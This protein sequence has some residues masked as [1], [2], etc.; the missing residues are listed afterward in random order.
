M[1]NEP[2]AFEKQI[3]QTYR[4]P[5][6]N[7]VFVD[8]L[9][10]RFKDYQPN[11]EVK[12]Q[13]TFHL[14]RG[15]AFAMSVLFVLATLTL[16]IGPAKVWAQIQ[17][18]LGFVPGVGLVD[19][20]SPF[21]QLAAPV[22]ATKDG[23]T[24][25]IQSA[26][27][28][29]DQTVITYNMSELPAD[30]KR[31]KFTDPEC[32]QSA[33]L[34]LPDGSQIESPISS[35][36]TLPDGSFLRQVQFLSPV[37]V[38]FNQA[39]LVFPC[40]EG[41]A[42]E[43]GLQNWQFLLKF[44]PAPEELISYPVTLVPSLDPSTPATDG[45]ENKPSAGSQASTPT[46]PVGIVDGD[47]QED[48]SLLSVVEK[49]D[50][51]WVTWCFPMK[52]DMNVQ[53]NGQ[54]YE[55]PFN[56]VLYD[57]N[58][59][60]LP[61]PSREAQLEIWKYE[62]GLREQLSSTDRLNCSSNLHTFEI[63]KSGVAFPVYAR[64]NVYERSFPEKQAFAD[65]EFDGSQVLASD[66]PIKVDKAIQIGSVKFKLVSIGKN[67]YGGYTFNFDGQDGQ[68]ITAEIG[69]VG[70]DSNFHGT[71]SFNSNDPYH[72]TLS[73][74]YPQIP[75]GSLT[76]RVS[77]PAVLGDLISFIGSWSPDPE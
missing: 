35:G 54:L 43:K 52:Y 74:M 61:E 17:S 26:F 20:S 13:R 42:R 76:V 60:E 50:S 10:A 75:T 4:L 36:G 69:L 38:Q 68:V 5:E 58:G 55:I 14:A 63:S 31:A 11:L 28:S 32:M 18:A 7:P 47:R 2:T 71:V 57:A 48:M 39:T 45:S 37:P 21:R 29:A 16:V 34:I 1:M 41:T 65:I 62:D 33:Y 44:K 70:Y 56:A 22:S 66:Q 19:I 67:Q 27:L 25:T 23:I 12:T 40:L 64:Q 3:K 77:R 51:Y 73:E 9:E 6:M 8:R 24:L 15:W 49:P 59:K 72:F 53:I 46:L 30:I